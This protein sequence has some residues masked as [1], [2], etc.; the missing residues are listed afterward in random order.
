MRK[1]FN[2]ELYNKYD[3]IAKE[4]AKNLIKTT[5]WDFT[6]HPNK[7]SVDFRIFNKDIHVGYLEV[8]VKNIWKDTFPFGEVNWPERKW[9]FCQL[10]KPTIFLI[11]NHDLTQYLTTTGNSLL[12]SKL[13]MVRNKY[14]KYGENFF[15]V[16]IDKVKFNDI[17]GELK[18]L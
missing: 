12:S 8:E 14:V 17:I 3:L 10:D 7:T 13:E 16:P 6:N 11:F 4:A 18:S 9:K 1:I 2:K 15:K 5:D